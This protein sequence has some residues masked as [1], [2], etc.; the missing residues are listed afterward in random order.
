VVVEMRLKLFSDVHVPAEYD[1]DVLAVAAWRAG[2][3]ILMPLD[4]ADHVIST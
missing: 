4:V 3:V 2:W 1:T